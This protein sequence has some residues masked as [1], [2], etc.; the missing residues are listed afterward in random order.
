VQR[1]SSGCKL[2]SGSAKQLAGL[3]QILQTNAGVLC[4]TVLLPWPALQADKAWI[5]I[6]VPSVFVILLLFCNCW[7][8]QQVKIALQG[9]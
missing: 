6:P 1:F 4:G 3:L 2:A 7:R 9:V 8:C 5:F